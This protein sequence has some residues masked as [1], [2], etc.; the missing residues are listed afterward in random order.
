M[1]SRYQT[2]YTLVFPT[3]VEN[4]TPSS[5]LV[6]CPAKI[7]RVGISILQCTK[8][9]TCIWKWL[10]NHRFPNLL[11]STKP[12]SRVSLF[13]AIQETLPASRIPSRFHCCHTAPG[14]QRVKPKPWGVSAFLLDSHQEL[15]QIAV[16][17]FPFSGVETEG[18]GCMRS[19]GRW[20][21]SIL[22]FSCAP[23]KWV[24]V[25]TTFQ[26]CNLKKWP[27]MRVAPK[28]VSPCTQML[29]NYSPWTPDEQ[30]GT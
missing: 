13:P 5:S 25:N 15:L 22:S 14:L 12:V 23:V 24:R 10:G 18:T 26:H 1:C 6:A 28:L 27:S 29:S 21:G 2:T 9:Y 3:A 4:K 8:T 19:L 16:P 17:G 20:C 11:E 7:D 30:H